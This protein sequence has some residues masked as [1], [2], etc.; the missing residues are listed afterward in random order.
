MLAKLKKQFIAINMACVGI[1]L[2]IV[3]LI[4]GFSSYERI[5][6]DSNMAL[7]NAFLHD[8]KGNM[9]AWEIGPA[10]NNMVKKPHFNSATFVVTLNSDNSFNELLGTNIEIDDDTI[11]EIIELCLKQKKDCGIIK[12]SSLNLSLKYLIK[13]N[14][15]IL[16]IAFY[17]MSNDYNML[18]HLIINFFITGF[19]SMALF[20]LLSRKLAKWILKPVEESW[21]RQR[22]FVADASHELK[23]PLTVILANADILSSHS[24]DTIKNQSKWLN[25]IKAEADHMSGLV[26]DLLFLAKSD[27]SREK[28]SF[29]PVNVSDILW[30][31]YLPF[32]SVA[33][34]QGKQLDAQISPDIY[35]N[36]DSG[37]LKQL[38]MILL[39]NAC[40]Y[41]PDGGQISVSLNIKH[42]KMIFSVNNSGEPIE[43]VHLPHLFERFYRA[44]ESRARQK[45]GYGLGLSIAKTI[46]EM[47]NGKISVTS[48]KENGTT[49]AVSIPL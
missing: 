9:P 23:T 30:N 24:E 21:D 34:E 15:G 10:K 29:S 40:K 26:N 47:H 22:Q 49:F 45:G 2:L 35:I 4:I 12:S 46:T 16:E 13:D 32:E 20:Y 38:M 19:I 33:F 27:A 48:T 17:D 28:I 43:A 7:D 37:K 31:V 42:D 1:I 41:T 5:V 39:D 25:Y 6:R 44:E 18:L 36:G 3:F 11:N 14:D 8:D